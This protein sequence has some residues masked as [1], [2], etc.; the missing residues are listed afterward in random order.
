MKEIPK[1]SRLSSRSF[2]QDF[3]RLFVPVLLI[4]GGMSL[5][6]M[7]QISSL[8]IDRLSE[9]QTNKVKVAVS[10][11]RQATQKLTG[12]A[13]Y[14]ANHP[15]LGAGVGP[16]T[17]AYLNRL[18][19]IF[20]PYM[21]AQHRI[22]QIRVINPAG[23]EVL[24][25]NRTVDGVARLPEAD[26]QDKSGR[27]YVVEAMKLPA[28]HLY[29]S[30]LD[31]NIEHGE[32]EKPYK[33]T[34]RLAAPLE[35][36]KGGRR[37]IL[38]IN[39]F[40]Q[41]LLRA[42]ED[43]RAFRG[44][45]TLVNEQGYW[46]MGEQ[47][48]DEWGFMF[49]RRITMAQRSPMVWQKINAV[50]SGQSLLPDGLWTWA[51]VIPEQEFQAGDTAPELGIAA[52]VSGPDQHRWIIISHIPGKEILELKTGIL[53]AF[54]PVL[55][56]IF[57]VLTAGCAWIVRAR[58]QVEGLNVQ[59]A[60]RAEAAEAAGRAKADFVANMSHE[61]RTPMN[62]ILGIAHLQ[63]QARHLDD[64]YSMALK[65]RESGKTLLAII[66]DILDFSK[67]EAGGLT[68]EHVPFRL[69]N[70]IDDLATIIAHNAA[71]HDIEVII[72][73]PPA[74][75]LDLVGDP[76]RLTQIL[77]NLANN[78][79]KFT[80]VGQVHVYCEVLEECEKQVLLRFSVVDTG[81][82]IPMEK[83]Q[84]IFAAFSQA[85]SD[86]TRRFG[87]TG[88][89]LAICRRL[90]ALMRGEIGVSSQPGEG[91]RFWFAVP[92]ERAGDALY[93]EPHMKS[94]RALIADDNDVARA[95]LKKTTEQLGWPAMVVES[96]E[97][98]IHRLLTAQEHGAAY[99]II[100][101]DW[102]MPGM[103]GLETARAIRDR[104]PEDA[105][106]II[107]MVTAH[108]REALLSEPDSA[109]TDAVLVKPITASSLY[110][111][112][113]QARRRREGGGAIIPD[114]PEERRLAGMRVLVVDDAP[115][116]REVAE[117]ILSAEGALV[118]LAPDGE[119]AVKYLKDKPKSMDIVLMDIQMPGM[120]GCEA[121]RRIRALPGLG[122]VPVVALTAGV[123]REQREAALAAGMNDF[124]GK[125]FDVDVTVT[126][127]R[128]LTQW[129]T[130]GESG[131]RRSAGSEAVGRK[132]EAAGLPGLDVGTALKVWR[133][134]ARYKAYLRQ[135]R[136][137]NQDL[138]ATL[139]AKPQGERA[140]LA[141]AIKG[142]AANLGLGEVALWAGRLEQSLHD[143]VAA[144]EELEGLEKA[145]LTALSSIAGYLE[146]ADP[147]GG[148]E[149]VVGNPSQLKDLLEK[150][151]AA[152]DADNPDGVEQHLEV[153]ALYLPADRL[154]PLRHAIGSFDFRGGEEA[155]RALMRELELD[156][157]GA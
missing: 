94:V 130:R 110:N 30:R 117:M 123:F 67:I 93:S 88:L 2:L 155:I 139:K 46:L 70:V 4:C 54:S 119:T 3:L 121:T 64:V 41:T 72:S 78:A 31:L 133:D 39:F 75:Y 111:A 144:T 56:L 27:D 74:G 22:D 79:V 19:E 102:K 91:S 52:G 15:E 97:E 89:G 59:L 118:T 20:V 68:L 87:G 156:Q 129:H 45:S 150:A 8:E 61:I 1:S 128:A 57:T 113:S 107:V 80:Q 114:M 83:Q 154:R 76:L 115:T 28:G 141:H 25:L 13:V 23:L 131:K 136:Q 153:L 50:L 73:P 109:L 134:P 126:L 12:D 65:I 82:G 71:A 9:R 90:V 40:G 7:Y 105:A 149:P 157:E 106:P 55:L 53:R 81:I 48:E 100:M 146:D 120:D 63:L 49:D 151:L 14:L 84:E 96:G 112:V 125:P 77:M 127:M 29:A 43:I 42:Q 135:F 37:G 86:T 140:A 122:E 32:I 101:L 104:I 148:G 10:S 103:D 98:V 33:P 66:N 44:I 18:A 143:G 69:D 47:P 85:G 145:L 124:V 137:E 116:N 11:L 5:L 21:T 16:F 92:F 62:A 138:V 35:D 95:A 24:R 108:S 132:A 36:E 152:C 34:I 17:P 147:H 58:R 38:V 6:Y 60:E 142:V 51:S 99:D 26:L